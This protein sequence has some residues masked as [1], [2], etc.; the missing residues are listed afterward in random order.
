V[1]C[2][3]SAGSRRDESGRGRDVEGRRAAAARAGRVEEV[4]AGHVDVL[5]QLAHRAG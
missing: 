2:D 4:V 1:L 3:A 5:G